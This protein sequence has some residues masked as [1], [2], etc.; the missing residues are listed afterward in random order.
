MIINIKTGL[1]C[2]MIIFYFLFSLADAQTE[3]RISCISLVKN[4][5]IVLRWSPASLPVWQT[6]IKYGYIIRRYTIAR[7]GEFIQDGLKTPV[8]LTESPIRPASVEH[9]EYL[10]KTLPGSSVVQ[11]AIYG[12]ATGPISVS[13]DFN[14]FMKQ[15]EEQ[16]TRLGFALFMC[17]MSPL[18]AE[19]AGLLYTDKSITPGE[20]YAYSISMAS[21]PD[22]LQ[23]EPSVVVADAGIPT[24]LPSILDIKAIFTDKAVRFR[25]PAML[26]KGIYTAYIIEKSLNGKNFRSVSELP[27]VNFSENPDQEYFVYTDSLENNNTKV[28]YNVKGISPFG[29]QG[30]PSETISG[31]GIPDF[32]AY[33]AID[34]A[35]VGEK[36]QVIIEWRITE[37]QNSS[38]RNISVMRSAAYNG[39]F[40]MLNKK[41]LSPGTTSFTDYAPMHANYYRIKLEG[42]G[43][44][45]SYSFPFFV[46]TEDND[47]PLPPAMLSGVVDSAGKVTIIWKANTELDLMGYKVF[48]S[49]SLTDE[50]ISLEKEIITTNICYDSI[51]LN[52][53]TRK[54]F[55][56]VVAID[57]NY[58]SS[59]YSTALELSRPDTIKPSPAVINK[60]SF[61]KGKVIIE[62]EGSPSNDISLYELYRMAE[63]DSVNTKV[64][65]WKNDLPSV[66][67]DTPLEKGQYINYTLIT[68]DQ[69]GNNSQHNR[70]VFISGNTSNTLELTSEQSPDGKTI[71]ITWDL[72]EGFIPIRTIIY[73]SIEDQPVSTYKTLSGPVQLFHDTEIDISTRYNYMIVS[74]SSEDNE[75]LKSEKLVFSPSVK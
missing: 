49:N 18:V 22:G 51:N 58:N 72:P 3:N 13:E 9:F 16:E 64:I 60:I 40:E 31:K 41:P 63:R 34:T 10:A 43:N 55:Y 26:Y 68:Y 66:Y 42:D 15:Y 73:K 46:Q 47:P 50:P 53:L 21:I 74:F 24:V 70:R 7:N 37:N 14:V 20:R 48:R 35:W 6:G 12:E 75:V 61:S 44:L 62:N 32:T 38:V 11:D 67:N 33:A 71:T 8:T 25:W 27:L 2:L 56:Q 57:N 69:A 65:T 30:P 19:A 23:V 28:W 29:E 54:I 36:K 1:V 17:D 52:T 39:S 45:S 4:D 5:S 59:E